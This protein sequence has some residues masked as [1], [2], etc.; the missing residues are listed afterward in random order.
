MAQGFKESVEEFNK[1]I[2]TVK[3]YNY[4]ENVK[5]FGDAQNPGVFYSTMQR[6]ADLYYNAKKINSKPDPKNVIDSS[7]LKNAQ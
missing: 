1:G 6:A 5:M 3:L 2:K 7:Y 4:D